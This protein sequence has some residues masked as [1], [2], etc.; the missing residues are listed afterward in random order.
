MVE[1]LLVAVI[2]VVL[3]RGWKR[4][5]RLRMSRKVEALNRGETVRVRC[6]ARFRRSGGRRLGAYLMVTPKGVFV[7]TTDGTVS[8][9]CLG[10]PGSGVEIV[11]EQSV[12]VYDVDGRQLEV[13]LPAGEEALLTAVAARLPGIDYGWPRA[14]GIP[15]VPP[16]PTPG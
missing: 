6:A 9:L 4:W 3:S 12:I 5:R 7:S 11:A 16:G 13:L 15:P 1:D 2:D 14:Q 8:N 10:T